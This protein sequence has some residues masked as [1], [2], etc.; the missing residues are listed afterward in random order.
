MGDGPVI[1]IPIDLIQA[2]SEPYRP[3]A[4]LDEPT[5][6]FSGRGPLRTFDVFALIV[7][8]M[9]GTGI[10]TAPASVFLITGNKSLTLGL[11]GIG[12]LYSLV[13]LTK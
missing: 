1:K 5:H 8:K 9:V 13:R 12:F 2:T 6:G 7:N 4:E 11:F 3:Q 10:Y